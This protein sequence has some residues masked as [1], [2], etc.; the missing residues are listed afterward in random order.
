[1]YSLLIL[2]VWLLF[3]HPVFAQTMYPTMYKCTV[4]GV[5]T[6]ADQPCP[7]VPTS[8]L[9]IVPAPDPDPDSESGAATG[10]QRERTLLASLEQQRR[11]REAQA[12]REAARA[13]RAAAVQ[14][15]RCAKLRL[16]QRW[17]D[18]DLARASGKQRDA[19]RTKAQRHRQEMAL[20]CPG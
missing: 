11:K 10:A 14:Q 20:E 5:P 1:M 2:L 3:V 6:Y 7:G 8:E 17:A 18:E 13:Q 12:Q 19:L 4:N 16:H 15:R 9:R